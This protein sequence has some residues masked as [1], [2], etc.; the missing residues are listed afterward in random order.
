MKKRVFSQKLVASIA[1]TIV[2]II[3]IVSGIIIVNKG[4][5][6]YEW[7]PNN[8]VF[9]PFLLGLYVLSILWIMHGIYLISPIYIGAALYCFTLYALE[10][11]R[12][13]EMTEEEEKEQENEIEEEIRKIRNLRRKYIW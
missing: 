8:E 12:L 5:H 13:N 9:I 7:L 3:M 6:W 1:R 11:L 4:F 2:A 10:E